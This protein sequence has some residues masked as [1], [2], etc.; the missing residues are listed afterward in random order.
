[1]HRERLVCGIIIRKHF[2]PFKYGMKW[3]CLLLDTEEKK[4]PLLRKC[5]TWNL[6]R[7]TFPVLQLHQS[8]MTSLTKGHES[9]FLPPA[10][11]CVS[12]QTPFICCLVFCLQPSCTHLHLLSQTTRGGKKKTKTQTPAEYNTALK[13]HPDYYSPLMKLWGRRVKSGGRENK[14]KV[15]FSLQRF[16]LVSD[17]FRRNDHKASACRVYFL[18]AWG[19]NSSLTI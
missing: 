11:C 18:C 2:A 1:M 10:S 8:Q 7:P 19:S 17:L 13:E 5:L 6:H 15:F 9:L 16:I 3:T 4:Q 14:T 12:M